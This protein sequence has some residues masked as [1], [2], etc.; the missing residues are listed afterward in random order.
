MYPKEMKDGLVSRV[1]FGLFIDLVN[2]L[3]QTD[4]SMKNDKNGK[5]HTVIAINHIQDV[6]DIEEKI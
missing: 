3:E 6:F 4:Y 2:K 1:L 5:H